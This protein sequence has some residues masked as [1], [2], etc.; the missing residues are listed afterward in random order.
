MDR[1]VLISVI[2]IAVLLPFERLGGV[3][4]GGQ[5]LRLSQLALAAAWFLFVRA[6]LNG[7]ATLTWKNPALL[8]LAGF[9]AAAG[10]SLLNAENFSRSL[11]VL[12]FTIFTASLALLLPNVLRHEK[13]RE[14]PRVAQG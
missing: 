6:W 5:N 7:H 13:H 8:A 14:R 2:A 4:V 9:C 11:L 1:A 12:G 3:N 10:L